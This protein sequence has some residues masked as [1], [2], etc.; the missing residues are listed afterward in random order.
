MFMKTKVKYKIINVYKTTDK[1]AR[2]KA[3][4]SAVQR[5]IDRKTAA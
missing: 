2:R 5:C 3:V 1:D 4:T